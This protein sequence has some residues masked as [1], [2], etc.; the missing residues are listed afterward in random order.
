MGFTTTQYKGVVISAL[1]KHAPSSLAA[2]RASVIRLWGD[3]IPEDLLEEWAESWWKKQR[4]TAS[5]PKRQ[6]APPEREVTLSELKVADDLDFLLR[7]LNLSTSDVRKVTECVSSLG[8]IDSA[9]AI[10][11]ELRKLRN[12]RPTH[13]RSLF[14]EGGLSDLDNSG[15]EDDANAFSL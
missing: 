1:S 4:A 15:I 10:V 6:K 7:R 12:K 9:M 3:R 13:E 14:D 5:S 11:E 8:G 2:A